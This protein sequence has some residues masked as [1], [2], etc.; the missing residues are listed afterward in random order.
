LRAPQAVALVLFATAGLVGFN[1]ILLRA[2]EAPPDWS[3]AGDVRLVV[4]GLAVALVFALVGFFIGVLNARSRRQHGFE[5]VSIGELKDALEDERGKQL[6]LSRERQ[7]L[8]QKIV[9]LEDRLRQYLVLA[10]P[11]AAPAPLPLV[12]PEPDPETAVQLD[13]LG[14]RIERL[15]SELS[16]RRNRMVDLQAELSM[17]QTEAEA[18]RAEAEQL[19]SVTPAAATPVARLEL[20]G[21]PLTAVLEGIV[22][23]EGVRAALVADD[24][25]LVVDAAGEGLQPDSLAVVTGLV[26]EISPRVND[27]LPIGEIAAVA[28]GDEDGIV[29]EVRYFPLFG[30]RCSLAII[31]DDNHPHPEITRNA[32]EAITHRLSD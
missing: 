11:P 12:P 24:Q 9:A 7:E 4:L 27:L 28:L 3:A 1:A 8:R 20:E 21:Q 30:A 22:G 16:S 25:G 29:L 13:E 15:R 19:K 2:L 10:E 5:E 23:L 32:I 31:R 17:A 14:Q 26:N 6:T 18:A